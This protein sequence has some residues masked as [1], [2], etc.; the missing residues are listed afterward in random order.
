MV[1]PVV[2]EVSVREVGSDVDVVVIRVGLPLVPSLDV[3][4]E[5]IIVEVVA[6]GVVVESIQ[7]DQKEERRMAEDR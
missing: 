3:E 4:V 5:S 2:E 1:S 7:I 6:V